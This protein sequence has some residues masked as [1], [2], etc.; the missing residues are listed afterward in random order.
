MLKILLRDYPKATAPGTE[1]N[2]I[3]DPWGLSAPAPEPQV[4]KTWEVPRV[5]QPL[6]STIKS[7]EALIVGA[8]ANPDQFILQDWLKLKAEPSKK[9]TRQIEEILGWLYYSSIPS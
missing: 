7:P 4:T 8:A 6:I 5:V 2:P 1:A 9:L 3:P